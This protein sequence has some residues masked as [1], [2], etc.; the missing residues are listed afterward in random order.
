MAPINILKIRLSISYIEKKSEARIIELL[1]FFLHF[2][3]IKMMNIVQEHNE[4][5]IKNSVMANT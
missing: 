1:F 3:N 2:C 5:S 4:K